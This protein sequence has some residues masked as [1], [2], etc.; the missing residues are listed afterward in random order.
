[1]TFDKWMKTQNSAYKKTDDSVSLRALR[2]AWLAATKAEREA[3]AK[4]CDDRAKRPFVDEGFITEEEW[5][6]MARAN[7]LCADVIRMRS[8]V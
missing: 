6:S 8:N 4:V 2:S 3:C 5:E 7:E 1:M